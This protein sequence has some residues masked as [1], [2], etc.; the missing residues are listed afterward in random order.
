VSAPL[1]VVTGAAGGLGRALAQRLAADGMSLLLADRDEGVV[2]VAEEL[3]RD[4]ASATSLTADLASPGAPAEVAATVRASGN[5]LALLVNNAGITRDSRA[6]KMSDEAFSTVVEVDLVAPLR[7]AEALRELFADGAAVVNISSRAAFGNFGQANY[8]AAKSGLLGATRALA[9][10][11][12]PHVRVNAVAPGLIDTPMTR[13]MPDHVRERLVEKIPLARIGT[14]AD[15]A[16]V[17]A[18]L[19]GPASRYVT[20][21]VLVCCGG[22][23]IAP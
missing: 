2:A 20:G 7:L 16:D 9:L 21:Q 19:G 3:R 8:A 17:V 22:R 23:S 4:G 14:P 5:S 10:Q 15:V 12:A 13:A 1:A 6:T 18:F 11:W